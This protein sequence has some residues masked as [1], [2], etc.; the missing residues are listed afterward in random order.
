MVLQITPAGS[1]RAVDPTPLVAGWKLLGRLTTGHRPVPGF[2][3]GGAYGSTNPTVG[4]LLLADGAT[5][6][7][8][9]LADPHVGL[10]S[11]ERAG[12]ATGAVAQPPLALI[13]YLS[14]EGLAPTVS[15]LPCG[16]GGTSG[17]AGAASST[18]RLEI[19]ALAGVPVAGAQRPGG[20]VDMTIRSLLAL[21]G[22]LHPARI[23]SL[24]SYPWQPTALSLPDHASDLEVDLGRAAPTGAR[25]APTSPTTSQWGRLIGRIDQLGA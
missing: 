25:A 4:Q 11:C 13:E 7:R 15:G 21:R 17:A 16:G 9:V 10:D 23:V 14:Y 20:F 22:T 5:L 24:L 6:Q 18:T 12:I 8:A 19:T 1:R 3:A 2:S